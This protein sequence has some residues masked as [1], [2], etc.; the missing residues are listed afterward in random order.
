[1]AFLKD[2]PFPPFFL[3][4]LALVSF[5]SLLV[6]TNQGSRIQLSGIFIIDTKKVVCKKN[7][8][9]DISGTCLQQPRAPPLTG[10]DPTQ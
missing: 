5:L 3:S 1:M 9:K 8:A 7:N 2:L 4:I 6:K 10:V